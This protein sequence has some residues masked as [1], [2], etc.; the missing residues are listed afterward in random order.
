MKVPEGKKIY[1]GNK[2]YKAGKELP[3]SYTLPEKK[4][5]SNNKSKKDKVFELKD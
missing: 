4:N 3:A 5:S 2:K 1:I